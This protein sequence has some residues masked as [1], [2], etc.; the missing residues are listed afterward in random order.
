MTDSGDTAVVEGIDRGEPRVRSTGSVR[1][2][3]SR[4]ASAA[5]A[6]PVPTESQAVTNEG[7]H[8]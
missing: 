2:T 4:C 1:P 7:D 8:E 5:R 6:G 3:A